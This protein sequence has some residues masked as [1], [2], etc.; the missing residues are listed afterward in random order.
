[1]GR[2]GGPVPGA[3]SD[4]IGVPAAVVDH[5]G[6][7]SK[8]GAE[9]ERIAGIDYECAKAYLELGRKLGGWLPPLNDCNSF[10][11]EVLNNCKS[12]TKREILKNEYGWVTGFV[13]HPHSVIYPDGSIRDGGYVTS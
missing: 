7:S 10:S 8:P 12:E 6:E 5:A 3:E 2:E 4:C 13:D 9:C 1:M 11:R